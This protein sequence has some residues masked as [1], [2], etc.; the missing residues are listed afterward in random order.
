M[1]YPQ[2]AEGTKTN[3]TDLKKTL[4]TQLY[5]IM[6][7]LSNNRLYKINVREYNCVFNIQIVFLV[8][9]LLII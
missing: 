5:A 9:Y 3:R 7:R 2:P 1:R 6:C 4:S 8:L